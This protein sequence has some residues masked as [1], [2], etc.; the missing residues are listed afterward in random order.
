MLKYR[1]YK[2]LRGKMMQFNYKYSYIA[3]CIGYI[4]QS[5]VINFMPLLFAMFA[6]A[7]GITLDK[8]GLLITVSFI[9][10]TS[11]DFAAAK[12]ADK[13]SLRALIIFAHLAATSGL[14]LLSLAPVISPDNI[15]PWL[16]LSILPGSMGGGL[17]E[18]L[19]SPMVEAM[20]M[21]NKPG[22]M[23]ILHSCYSWGHVLVTVISTLFFVFIGMDK[24]SYLPILWAIIPFLNAIAFLK[25]PVYE[26]DE[27]NQKTSMKEILST[28]IF[29]LFAILML[30]A[31]ASEFAMSQ[32]SSYFVEM[33]LKVS[34][35]V[36]DLLGPCAFSA[37]MGISR[38]VYSRCGAGLDLKKCITVCSFI[39]ILCYGIATLSPYP[40]VS[41]VGCALCGFSVAIMW[42]GVYSLSAKMYAKGGT[43]MFAMLALAGDMGCTA[44]PGI[45]GYISNALGGDEFAIKCGLLCTIIFPVVMI[46]AVK[47]LKKQNVPY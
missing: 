10:Q 29:W 37:L 15:Y 30:G 36:G 44:G 24:W 33:G 38:V 21:K 5:I 32:W 45:V 16:M 4:T 7:Y 19:L 17:T 12:Y 41:V 14:V 6:T 8:I 31:G 2:F 46:F 11:M 9:V 43:T 23:S 18:V 26:L 40:M 27:D 20:P 22:A 1:Q 3:C 25:L 28:R 35:T 34:K 39:T 47:K 42:P 13:F